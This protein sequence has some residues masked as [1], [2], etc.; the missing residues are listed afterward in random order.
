MSMPDLDWAMKKYVEHG[1]SIKRWQWWFYGIQENGV[2][3]EHLSGWT[4]ELLTRTLKENG[5]KEDEI[6]LRERKGSII[7]TLTKKYDS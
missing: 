2:G 6:V 4:P 1:L 5:W 7:A 3:W